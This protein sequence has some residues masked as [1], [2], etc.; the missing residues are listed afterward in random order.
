MKTLKRLGLIAMVAVL[1]LSTFGLAGCGKKGPEEGVLSIRYHIGGFGE[2]WLESARTKFLAANPDV[3]DIVL[4]GQD[5]HL[6]ENV[7]MYIKSGDSPDIVMTQ[8]MAWAQLVLE[9]YIEPLDDVY[10]T[11]VQ[12]SEGKRTIYDYLDDDFADYG[13]MQRIA[14]QGD[15]H[16]WVLPWSILTC[17][18]A[19]NVD[20]LESTPRASTGGNWTAAPATVD[21]LYEYV[22]DVNRRNDGVV[23]FAWGGD[24][25]NWMLFPAYVWWAQ[26]QGVD[27]SK[28]DGQ[29]SYYDFW[30]FQSPEVYKQDGISQSLDIIRNLLVDGNGNWKNSLDRPDGLS[31]LDVETAFYDGKAAMCFAGSWLENEMGGYPRKDNFEM[32]MMRTPKADPDDN[33]L[34]NNANAG[35]IM[36]IPKNALNKDIAKRFLTFLCSEEML[37]EF[38]DFTGMMRPFEYDP[39]ELSTKTYSGFAESCFD[40]YLN[41]DYNLFEF[42]KNAA[43]KIQ[44]DPEFQTYIYTYKR[45]ELFQEVTLNTAITRLKT[46]TGAYVMWQNNDSVYELV[47]KEFPKWKTELGLI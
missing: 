12:T 29:G 35:D 45:P 40:L 18:I 7:G 44:D 21:E 43:K 30:E 9:G 22:A 37:V 17:S 25:L 11:E 8:N 20:Y 34:I 31:T 46:H 47:K 5:V 2:A 39:T 32:R 4:D 26:L 38:S 27:E 33:T 24:G 3:K 14:G 1:A 10:A 36:L 41:S 6:R 42:P 28:I 16:A 13:M 23:P 15:M 19:Y